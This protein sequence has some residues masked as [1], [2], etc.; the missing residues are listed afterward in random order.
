M[1]FKLLIYSLI[2]GAIGGGAIAA[3]ASRMFH[4]PE[5]QS[6]GAFRT[7]GEMNACNGDPISHF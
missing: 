6:M 1:D 5:K 3:G 4:A 2:V 7:L